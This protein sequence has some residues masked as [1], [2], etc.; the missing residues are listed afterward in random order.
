MMLIAI[1]SGACAA[2]GGSSTDTVRADMNNGSSGSGAT[3]DPGTG[4]GSGTGGTGS[5]G[6]DP[7]AT[8][9]EASPI[10]FIPYDIASGFSYSYGFSV[11]DYDRDGKPDISFFDSWVHLRTDWRPTPGAIGYMQW[12]AG[13][14]ETIVANEKFDYSPSLINNEYL[15]ERHVPYDIDKDGWDD[16][17]GVSNSH[18]SVL[19]YINPHTRGAPWTR[20][21]ISNNTPGAV[22]LAVADVNGDGLPDVFVSMRL[23]PHAS[24]PAV[25]AG[26]AWL[27][28]T[29][30]PGAEFT[31]H[32]IDTTA[33]FS[34]CRT[35]Q[36]GD[37]DKDGRMDVLV[38]DMVSGKLAWYGQTAQGTWVRH[39]I[40][41]VDVT[42]GQFGKLVDFDGDGLLDIIMPTR[43]G[44]ALLKNVNKGQSWDIQPI[45]T[46]GPE[47]ATGQVTEVAVG[48][49]DKDGQPDIV[50]TY[51]VANPDNPDAGGAYWASRKD[52]KWHLYR[53][54]SGDSRAVAVQLVDY[55]GD[56]DL[57][58]VVDREYQS[59]GV[60]IWFNKLLNPPT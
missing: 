31:Y 23:Q 1:F 13:D 11:D 50:F 3:T 18:D 60:T 25:R 8:P 58:I 51:F 35:V 22:N 21:L 36:A 17:V 59:N 44:V 32:D 45:A 43:N 55:D 48:D 34:D 27:E 54:Y 40:E 4:S 16:I 9:V 12:N 47:F 29:G 46:F 2:C 30:T 42:G 39:E 7:S 37:I 15:F 10:Q 20:R 28:N 56:G 26:I 38:S 49:I 33:N 53:L 19:A 52:G 5:T 14:R 6:G 57:D 41:G 24:Y